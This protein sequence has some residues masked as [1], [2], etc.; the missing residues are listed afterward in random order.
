M[1]FVVVLLLNAQSSKNV[2]AQNIKC[3][4]ILP[5]V[6]LSL[7]QTYSWLCFCAK[8]EKYPRLKVYQSLQSNLWNLP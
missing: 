6:V 7:T 5:F 4:L 2:H 1:I 8:N 3:L